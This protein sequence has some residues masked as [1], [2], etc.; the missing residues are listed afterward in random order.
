[1]Y[2]GVL[3]K[4]GAVAVTA[5]ALWL[6]LSY[7]FPFALP[8]A[9]AWAV[10]ACLQ[11]AVRIMSGRFGVS[12]RPVAAVFVT[13]SVLG[14]G[15]LIFLLVSR[16]LSEL[17]GFLTLLT[18]NAEGDV[19]NIFDKLRTFLEKLPFVSAMGEG[20][21]DAVESALTNIISNMTAA[22]PGWI[23]RVLG[24]L[25]GFF[26]FT[27]IL[28]MASYY[29]AADFDVIR[30]K[31]YNSLPSVFKGRWDS[32]KTRLMGAGAQYLK[33]CV[34]LAFITFA[35]LLVGFLVLEIPY[36][37][38]L[39][40]VIALV[41]M[42]PILGAGTVLIPWSIWEWATGNGYYAIGL[43]IV[44]AVVSVVR[45]FA[46]PRIISSGIGLSPITTL[47]S[48]YIGFRLYGL[49]GLFLAP[50]FAVIILSALP[51]NISEML[52]MRVT[53]GKT[54]EK[55]Y[56]KRKTTGNVPR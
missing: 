11:P 54:A 29:F 3:K 51:D 33:A 50:L 35:E 7:L 9:L 37:F 21:A 52:G 18:Q 1:M 39:A 13:V 24:A 41:D 30:E 12:R 2:S 43:L 53:D 44:F 48:M 56:K 26:I 27:V 42:L 5:F 28:I 32:F 47:V 31:V 34:A 8:F 10:A 38:M 20:F 45:R 6:A 14:L 25:P 46:E 49:G 19:G 40:I 23:G 17:G 4:I 55:V 22:I 16:F 15:T 36:A